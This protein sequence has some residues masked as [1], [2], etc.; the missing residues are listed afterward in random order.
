MKK[1]RR[2]KRFKNRKTKKRNKQYRPKVQFSLNHGSPK[3]SNPNG[4]VTSVTPNPLS[5]K[6]RPYDRNID[7]WD[8]ECTLLD[9]VQKSPEHSADAELQ[10]L[11]EEI[12]ATSKTMDQLTEAL[13][14]TSDAE[15]EKK[16]QEHFV[17][18]RDK[19]YAAIDQ[20]ALK[21]F[22]EC[23]FGGAFSD[24][25]QKYLQRTLFAGGLK[26]QQILVFVT[27]E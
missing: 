16:L 13:R 5:L 7:K 10:K 4:R 27:T 22:G 26:D 19:N 11:I 8:E 1:Q 6:L 14:K 18:A 12:K 25:I 17:I 3:R 20:G 23:G 24:E 15:E 21:V 9:Y 2:N